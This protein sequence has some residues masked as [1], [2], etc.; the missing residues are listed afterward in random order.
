MVATVSQKFSSEL[1]TTQSEKEN[2]YT[3]NRQKE[4]RKRLWGDA[5]IF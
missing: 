3:F 4:K 2:R 1:S 5:K